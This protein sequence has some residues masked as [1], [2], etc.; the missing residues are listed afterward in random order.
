MDSLPDAVAH[1]DERRPWAVEGF[2]AEF[3]GCSDAE[4]A[5]AGDP[6]TLVKGFIPRS[7]PCSDLTTASL[8]SPDVHYFASRQVIPPRAR[9]SKRVRGRLPLRQCP[10]IRERELGGHRA[11]AFRRHDYHCTI[12]T[13]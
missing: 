5:A 8:L 6:E 3:L 4:F 9:L 1:F 7:E 10:A 12:T 13:R 2:A 11:Y